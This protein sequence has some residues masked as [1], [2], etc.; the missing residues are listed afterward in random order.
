MEGTIGQRLN[1]SE[2]ITLEFLALFVK[3]KDE[4]LR[5]CVDY[6]PLNTVIIKNMYPLPHI[7]ILF[8]QLVSAK[9]FSKIDIH[10]DYHQIKSI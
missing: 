2:F 9:V 4:A 6:W 10:S 5:L 8:H 1:P 7:D 3:K